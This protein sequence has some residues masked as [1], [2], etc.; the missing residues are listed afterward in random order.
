MVALFRNDRII[1]LIISLI[2][3][4]VGWGTSLPTL[5]SLSLMG[6]IC[7]LQ[8]LYSI[9]SWVKKGNQLLS[10]YIIFLITLYIFSTGQSFLWALGLES[11]RT[12]IGFYGV[13]IA[14]IF[15]AQIFTQIMLA[16]FQ[17]GA[18]T[19]MVK[20][21]MIRIPKEKI[22]IDSTKLKKVGWILF[23]VS[24]IPYFQTM[25]TR[26]LL[27]LSQG[28]GA[29]FEGEEKVGFENIGG[30]ISDYYIPSIICLFIAYRRNVYM[31]SFIT[32]VLIINIIAILITGGRSNAVIL[33]ALLLIMYNY[34]V[35]KFKR[36]TFLFGILGAFFLLQILA[37][38][39]SS[40][41]ELGRSTNFNEVKFEDNA[42]VDAIAEMG[43]TM[44]CLIKTQNLVPDKFDYK[45][46]KSYAYSFTT[47][48]PNIGLWKIHPAKKESNLSNWLTETLGLSFGTGFS[49]C[50][51]AYIN[52]GYFCFVVFF[53]WGYFLANIFGKI[54]ISAKTGDWAAL[55]FLLI[56]F[57][58]FLKLPRNNFIN[59]VR[60]I[61]FVAGPI[62]L[63]CNNFKF[64]KL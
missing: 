33:I 9:I 59:L 63:Y 58:F 2:S 1:L 12:L 38:V 46:G 35:S 20:I 57:W 15:K 29:L 4:F 36:K 37:Y 27:S 28:Y 25:I 43:S 32:F 3:L 19:Y 56:L 22:D 64:K 42:A 50:A 52:F 53:I 14:E 13:T 54:E 21:S 51:E 55:A 60:P 26:L 47:L 16:F 61:F 11:N 7:L 48:I 40:R 30:F 31:R 10:P 8:F 34:L 41:S 23:I 44:F 62:Y 18:S 6:W 49:M 5:Q 45:Y 24:V 17:I 39:G